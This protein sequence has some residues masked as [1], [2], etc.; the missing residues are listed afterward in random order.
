M[1]T[2]YIE[3]VVPVFQ[4]EVYKSNVSGVQW[5]TAVG[6]IGHLLYNRIEFEG[7]ENIDGELEKDGILV[8]ND[9]IK[10]LIF[11][12]YTLFNRV[13]KIVGLFMQNNFSESIEA[14]LYQF[15][16]FVNDDRNSGGWML[17]NKTNEK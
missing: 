17:Y 2:Y 1:P 8:I 15:C 10:A 12:D 5:N 14:F 7:K 4:E 11:F 16:D 3:G 6:K 9:L 13:P